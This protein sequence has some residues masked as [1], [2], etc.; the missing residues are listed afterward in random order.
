MLTHKILMFNPVD[1]KHIENNKVPVIIHKY[2]KMYDK[3]F[4]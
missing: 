3:K 2:H 1:F 4:I